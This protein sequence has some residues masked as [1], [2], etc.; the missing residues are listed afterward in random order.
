MLALQARR[1]RAA[2][3]RV[4][5]RRDR[6]RLALVLRSKAIGASL[7]EIKHYLDLCG[8]QGECRV[9]Q[10]WFVRERTDLAIAELKTKR[11]HIEAGLAELRVINE[12]VPKQ[13]AA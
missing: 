7:D 1:K 8:A 3:A 13:L 10:L 4:H 5:T 2:V 11:A 6:V 9:Q 12:A